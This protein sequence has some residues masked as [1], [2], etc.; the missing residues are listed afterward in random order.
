MFILSIRKIKHKVLVSLI[1]V[2]LVLGSLTIVFSY[3]KQKSEAFS[4]TGKYYLD[5]RTNEDRVKFLE[6]FG[7]EVTP[8]PVEV[9]DIIIPAKFNAV[10]ENYNNIQK[11]QG[12]DL[13]KYKQQSCTRYTYQI[14][15]YKNAPNN[16]RANILVLNNR[17]IG[18]DICSVELD[19]FMHGFV[20]REICS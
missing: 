12:L 18:G 1:L 15:N 7:W 3:N 11:T 2:V 13:S 4:E 10:Y 6:Q 17:V 19:G 5:A 16:V 14:L 9:C 8:E 20:S